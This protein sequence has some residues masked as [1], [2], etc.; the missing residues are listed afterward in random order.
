MTDI[1]DQLAESL[2]TLRT[3]LG[4]GAFD[5]RR[6]LTGFLLDA[7]PDARREIRVI[8]TAL[9]ED[10]PA[11]L[12]GADR[13]MLGLEMDRQANRLE[14]ATGLR[15][16]LALQV[17]RVLAYA[18]DLGPP[19]SV[20]AAG[21]AVSAPQTA[22]GSTQASVLPA[23][24]SPQTA[25]ATGWTPPAPTA[26]ANPDSFDRLLTR[27]PLI[28]RFHSLPTRTRYAIT[29]VI[30]ACALGLYFFRPGDTPGVATSAGAAATDHAGELRD[31]GVSAKSTLESDVGTPTPLDIPSGRRITTQE[32]QDLVAR[33]RRTL[34]IDVLDGH[35]PATLQ[36]A[37]YM[38]L[39]GYP[40]DVR[41][42]TQ[43]RVAAQLH[44]ASDGDLSRPLVF[45]CMGPVCWES[46]NA[47]LRAAA[48]GHTDL[49]WYRGGLAAWQAAG[50]PMQPLG[51]P[52]TEGGGQT[53]AP[54]TNMFDATAR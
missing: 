52:V 53:R 49:Y 19:P 12:L 26:S 9:D 40:G 48:A 44:T 46:Y 14:N 10:V 29:G 2:R 22:W 33:D 16:D 28:G 21:S 5:D 51:Q 50:L 24:A 20:Y 38:P 15:I 39:A 6:R 43:T 1:H 47:V 31:F 37:I 45:F 34:L 32:V 23:A 3:R 30:V 7:A 4:D 36:G 18:L 17:V 13:P 25:P 35:H 27:I 8:S 54:A 11:A 41:D 42:A